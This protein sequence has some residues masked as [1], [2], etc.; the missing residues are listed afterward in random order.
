MKT[1]IIAAALTLSG[2]S[3]QAASVSP[4]QP[5]TA[6]ASASFSAVATAISF[7]DFVE[8][9]LGAS[10]ASTTSGAAQTSL[11]GIESLVSDPAVQN[12]FGDDFFRVGVTTNSTIAD[13]YEA[14]ATASAD[15]AGAAD[16]ERTTV[17][18][19]QANSVIRQIRIDYTLQAA[20]DPGGL[21]G[22]ILAGAEIEAF[23]EGQS[24][25][26]DSVSAEGTEDA[27]QKFSSFSFNLLDNPGASDLGPFELDVTDGGFL[28]IELRPT[29]SLDVAAPAAVP[30]PAAGWLLAAGLGCL[31]GLRRRKRGVS[32][33][34]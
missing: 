19:V 32:E 30:L 10:D 12:P 16:A 25:F 1:F 5:A 17:W 21:T 20:T 4:F 22:D 14:S 8:V 28:T 11:S 23:Y 13:N 24:V 26:F 3:A 6:S 2:L 18:F 15:D 27:V 31:I 33:P 9:G 7:P 34:A 29:V